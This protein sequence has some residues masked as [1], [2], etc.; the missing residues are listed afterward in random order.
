MI[1]EEFARAARQLGAR[2]GVETT[3]WSAPEFWCARF[4]RKDGY[5]VEVSLRRAD[6]ER[7]KS[8]AEVEQELRHFLRGSELREGEPATEETYAA[9]VPRAPRSAP[10]VMPPGAVA[11]VTHFL[12][13]DV[14]YDTG[15]WLPLADFVHFETSRVEA[16]NERLRP[17]KE[18]FEPGVVIFEQL[19]DKFIG[20]KE[21]EH[22]IVR[23]SGIADDRIR[24]LTQALRES[25]VL[26]ASGEA[27]QRA[28]WLADVLTEARGMLRD[29]EAKLRAVRADRDEM[30]EK[31]E[32][33][34]NR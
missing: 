19:V 3:P 1:Y 25:E 31:L 28:N 34:E 8:A 22:Q 29:T 14:F 21:R 2:M 4:K 26:R 27:Q 30:R 32:A 23:A 7:M 13:H 5:Y 11:G 18:E 17:F 15:R 6:V 9:Y 16:M 10:P 24:E 33:K 20:H 12:D